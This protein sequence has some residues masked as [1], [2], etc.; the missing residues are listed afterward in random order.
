MWRVLY[1]IYHDECKEG[2][3]WHGFLF[4]PRQT[5]MLLLELLT[6]ARANANHYEQLHYVT[7]GRSTNPHGKKCIT[8]E[9]WTSIGCNA[10]QQE[11]LRKYPPKVSLGRKPSPHS[12]IELCPLNTLLLCKFVL[13]RENDN[14][15]KMYAGMTELQCIE[16]TFRMGIKGGIHKLFSESSPITIGNVFMD[17][18]E[19]YRGLYGRNFSI[20]R[21]LQRLASERRAYVSFSSDTQLIPQQSNHKQIRPGQNADDSHLLQLCDILLGGFR[22]HSCFGDRAHPRFQ[23]SYH[24]RVLL[25]HEQ[26]NAAR[27]AESRY[28]NGF[29]LQQAQIEH[30]DWT[31]LP[32][33]LAPSAKGAVQ[34]CLPLQLASS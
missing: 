15:Q 18:D 28:F 30:G 22:F 11:K 9:A 2:G 20:N 27:M 33:E 3:Y 12:R 17:G 16:T 29:S 31:F 5:R 26:H 4:V 10:L 1:D 8:T 23:V 24:C 25:D 13:F 21:T 19:H 6:R 14:H 7:I 32:L 34:E